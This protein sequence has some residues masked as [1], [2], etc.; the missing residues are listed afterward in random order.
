MVFSACPAPPGAWFALSGG[1]THPQLVIEPVHLAVAAAFAAGAVLAWLLL[2]CRRPRD[3]ALAFVESCRRNLPKRVILV[4]HGESEGNADH[5]LYRTK[6]DNLIELTPHGIEQAQAVG[7]R[8]KKVLGSD[9]AHLVVSPFERTLQVSAD[10]PALSAGGPAPATLRPAS[11]ARRPPSHRT[12][13]PLA[14]H[15]A[16]RPPPLS[17]LAAEPPFSDAAWGC[18]TCGRRLAACAP[19]SSPTSST[20]TSSR[21]CAS[22]SLATCRATSSDRPAPSRCASAASSTASRRARAAP[23]CTAGSARGGRGGCAA[24]TCAPAASAP[25]RW[26]S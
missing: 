11:P 12:A 4:R 15:R 20:R 22:R 1:A 16:T 14:P 9:R 10:V 3:P 13:K 2:A 17:S 5:T 24:S 26:S 21:A 8:L 19:P 18:A 23:T 7:H 6:A 25:T